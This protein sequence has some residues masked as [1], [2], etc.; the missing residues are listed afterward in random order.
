MRTATAVRAALAGIRPAPIEL[1]LEIHAPNSSYFKRGTHH[2]A[3]VFSCSSGP[4]AVCHAASTNIDQ[5]GTDFAEDKIP[6]GPLMLDYM[7]QME[8]DSKFEDSPVSEAGEVFGEYTPFSFITFAEE[9][10]N[11]CTHEFSRVIDAPMEQVKGFFDDWNNIPAAFDLIDTVCL[12]SNSMACHNSRRCT[13][14]WTSMLR[15]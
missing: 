14:T 15:K 4:T 7:Q 12:L 9:E 1:E 2:F 11:W 13:S 8:H 10:E 3:R 5:A 6:E